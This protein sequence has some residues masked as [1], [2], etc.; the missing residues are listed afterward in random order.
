M[1]IGHIDGFLNE[2]KRLFCIE[3]VILICNHQSYELVSLFAK[4]VKKTK[5]TSCFNYSKLTF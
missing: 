5:E 3:F 2:D 1:Y 4:H